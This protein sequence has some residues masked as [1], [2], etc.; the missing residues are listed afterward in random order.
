MFQYMVLLLA[1]VEDGMWVC[2][3]DLFKDKKYTEPLQ[4]IAS[5]LC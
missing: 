4:C 1:I 3:V 2:S 5:L